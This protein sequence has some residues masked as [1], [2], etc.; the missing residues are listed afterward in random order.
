MPT[1]LHSAAGK[2]PGTVLDSEADRQHKV[3]SDPPGMR[4][5]QVKL[6]YQERIDRE[7]SFFWLVYDL[8]K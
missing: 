4:I 8:F 1:W 6:L 7:E 2:P 3:S 5:K